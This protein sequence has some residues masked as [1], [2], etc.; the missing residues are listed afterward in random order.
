MKTAFLNM[1]RNLNLSTGK[2][3]H[4]NVLTDWDE[5]H[6]VQIF[7]TIGFGDDAGKHRLVGGY[8]PDGY[9]LNEVV[10]LVHGQT[11]RHIADAV[12]GLTFPC[13][14]EGLA[15]IRQRLGRN[16]VPFSTLD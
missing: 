12:A 2:N 10:E 13:T 1:C 15:A 7:T 8:G 14:P 3:T 9:A 16:S 6:H 5:N 4:F 11:H